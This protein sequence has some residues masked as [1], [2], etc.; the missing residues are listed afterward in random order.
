MN[1]NLGNKIR[2][3]RKEKNISQEVLAQYLGVSFQAVSKWENETAMPDVALIPAIAS[4]FGVSTDDLFDYNRLETE[5]KIY[6]ICGN[7]AVFRFSDPARSETIL[8]EGLKQYPGNDIILNNLLVVLEGDPARSSETISL[9]KTL[10]EG[11]T[12]AEVKYDALRILADT[13]HRTGQQALVKPTLEQ[14]P[15]IYFTKLQVMA[16]LLEGD[17]SLNAAK[18]HLGICFDH[19]LA[20][21]FV[22]RDR[23]REKGE[24]EE[25]IRYENISQ[26]VIEA[27]QREGFGN[28]WD[29]SLKQWIQ[30]YLDILA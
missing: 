24:E 13:Y 12:D 10:I 16:F 15:E 9:C 26:G 30:D 6:E 2:E 29:E 8:R 25:A 20:M 21:L 7:A 11:T 5:R 19:M 4:F 27:F 18:R 23:S 22:L 14:I 3:L 28:L 1:V 17:D